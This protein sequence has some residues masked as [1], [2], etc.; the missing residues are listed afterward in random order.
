MHTYIHTYIYIHIHANIYTQEGARRVNET[1]ATIRR[2]NLIKD[3]MVKR[4][5]GLV[6]DSM[7]VH[8]TELL[9]FITSTSCYNYPLRIPDAEQL[10]TLDKIR[11]MRRIEINL[12]K[13]SLYVCVYTCMSMCVDKIR[14]MRRIEINLQKVSVYVCLY[15]WMDVWVCVWTR[16]G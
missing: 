9:S 12:Q 3:L 8:G 7:S 6:W 15:G 10:R 14:M 4:I 2:D 16:L 1:Q 11:M 5:K 13:V